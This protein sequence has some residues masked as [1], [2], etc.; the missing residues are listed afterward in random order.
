MK[1]VIRYHDSEYV[2]M[3]SK[4]KFIC[5]KQLSEATQF[6]SEQEFKNIIDTYWI[7]CW[8]TY[9]E[10]YKCDILTY[11]EALIKDILM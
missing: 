9:S 1:Y 6:D 10:N 11:E 3:Y 7:T 5:V 4:D 2:Q 8:C